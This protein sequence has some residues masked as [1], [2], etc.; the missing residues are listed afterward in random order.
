M[1][2]IAPLL[3]L[4]LVV[5]ACST[6]NGTYDKRGI[7]EVSLTLEATTPSG[8]YFTEIVYFNSGKV[9]KKV[10]DFN[11]DGTVKEKSER[12]GIVSK[13]EFQKLES[14]VFAN[15]FFSKPDL[16]PA[17]SSK[18]IRVRND[19]GVKEVDQERTSDQQIFAV[20]GAIS[21]VK[22]SWDGPPR[23]VD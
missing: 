16:G 6:V 1:R 19:K 10:R 4:C 13:E 17:G 11:L 21:G 3:L 14:A 8:K 20:G 7:K 23:S 22:T 9:H 12:T 18:V 15:E 2:N 5:V